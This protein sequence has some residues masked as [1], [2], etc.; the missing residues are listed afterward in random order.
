MLE[1]HTNIETKTTTAAAQW[2]RWRWMIKV[3]HLTRPGCDPYAQ[4]IKWLRSHLVLFRCFRTGKQRKRSRLRC[5]WIAHSVKGN[6]MGNLC[7]YG[8]LWVVQQI[9]TTNILMDNGLE[10]HIWRDIWKFIIRRIRT[11]INT[12]NRK[13]KY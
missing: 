1:K 12:F 13:W 3:D 8:R 11:S 10:G 6:G 2:N 7:H 4:S 9:G 5:K